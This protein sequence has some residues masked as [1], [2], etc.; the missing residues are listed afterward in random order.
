[1]QAKAL[2]FDIPSDLSESRRVHQQIMAAVADGG[3][4]EDAIFA[5]K[6]AIEEALV[7][8]IKHGN[9]LDPRKRVH[10]EANVGPEEVEIIIEDEGPGFARCAVPDPTADENLTKCSGRGLL[11]MEAYMHTVEYS[12]NGRRVRLV[13]KRD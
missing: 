2:K 6:L 8:A 5:I 4:S 12:N 13:R 3:Y 1:M 9:K 10:V 11:L 7:N